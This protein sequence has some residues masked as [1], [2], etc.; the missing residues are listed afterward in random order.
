MSDDDVALVVGPTRACKM[1]Q[2]GREKLYKLIWA[3]EIASYREA[4]SRKIE[5][6]SI[7]AYIRRKLDQERAKRPQKRSETVRRASS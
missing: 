1:L 2:V 5:V 6:A 4:G 3:G 7:H